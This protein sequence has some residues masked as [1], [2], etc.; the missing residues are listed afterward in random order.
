MHFPQV[1]GANKETT[2]CISFRQICCHIYVSGIRAQ[3]PRIWT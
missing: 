3:R 2:D 1:H